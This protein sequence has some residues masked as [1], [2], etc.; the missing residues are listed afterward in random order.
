M[1]RALGRGGRS[2]QSLLRA[3]CASPQLEHLARE[4]RQQ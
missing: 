4:A 3:E 1:G 2:M